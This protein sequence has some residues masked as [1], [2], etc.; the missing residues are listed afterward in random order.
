M[1]STAYQEYVDNRELASKSLENLLENLEITHYFVLF[2][3]Y[4]I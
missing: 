1:N 4:I 2:Y 3:I